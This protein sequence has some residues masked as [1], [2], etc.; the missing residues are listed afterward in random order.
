MLPPVP[1]AVL[2]PATEVAAG[3]LPALVPVAAMPGRPAP[4]ELDEPVR[5]DQR[6]ARVT[7]RRDAASASGTP[8]RTAIVAPAAT[9]PAPP[10]ALAVA[11]PEPPRNRAAKRDRDRDTTRGDGLISAPLGP[12]SGAIAAAGGLAAGGG[13]G[14]A[15]LTLLLSL[16]A[17]FLAR[18]LVPVVGLPRPL[19]RAAR[20]ERPG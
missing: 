14:P 3:A 6:P 8:E 19:L 17:V 13:S 5:G 15:V 1:D 9:A 12:A 10:P 11:A 16:L 7:P 4:P 18:T 2:L 20:L